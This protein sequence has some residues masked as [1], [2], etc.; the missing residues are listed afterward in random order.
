MVRRAVDH[1]IDRTID[2]IIDRIFPRP[3]TRTVARSL[4]ATPAEIAPRR[5]DGTGR[6]G[7]RERRGLPRAAAPHRSKSD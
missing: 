4:G 6:A 5:R 7:S 1:A 2:R 3:I